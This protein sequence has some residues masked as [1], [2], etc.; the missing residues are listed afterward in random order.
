VTNGVALTLANLTISNG[1]VISDTGGAV[2]NNGTLVI[3]GTT[4]Y[5]NTAAYTDTVNQRLGSGGAIFNAGT[6]VI[7]NSTFFSN[8]ARTDNPF[9]AGWAGNGG[10]IYSRATGATLNI[11]GSTFSSNSSNGHIGG[12]AILN[13]DAMVITGTTFSDNVAWA[14]AGID[15]ESDGV[16]YHTLIT[17]TTFLRNAGDTCGGAFYVGG[18]KVTITDSDFITNTAGTTGGGIYAQSA[19]LVTVNTSTFRGNATTGG[20]DGGGGA[21]GNG[22]SNLMLQ[23][24]TF[25]NNRVNGTS[26]M[27]GGGAIFQSSAD[28]GRIVIVNSTLSGNHSNTAGGGIYARGSSVFITNTTFGSLGISVMN[29]YM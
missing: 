17:N 21:I 24:S 13:F 8:T 29:H 6:V 20:W 18:S 22:Y 5:S 2:F 11:S 12:G 25:E 10:A 19:V 7:T 16:T 23:Q 28:Y 4:F 1:Y 3:T 9:S 15:D 14:G 26:G 27:A